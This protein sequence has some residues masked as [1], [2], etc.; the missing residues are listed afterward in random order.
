MALLFAYGQSSHG[1]ATPIRG[2]P[3]D[4]LSIRKSN[5][6]CTRTPL[7]FRDRHLFHARV[8]A[9][10]QSEEGVG[11]IVGRVWGAGRICSTCVQYESKRVR[12][13]TVGHS[14]RRTECGIR[15][16]PRFRQRFS[17]QIRRLVGYYSYSAARQYKSCKTCKFELYTAF[18]H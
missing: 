12:L 16:V 14:I 3:R 10:S 13:S 2:T 11:C 4:D 18:G 8:N 9:M 15:S 6:S 5:A 7:G 17:W 1:V